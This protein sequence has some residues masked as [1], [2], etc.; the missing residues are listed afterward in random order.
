MNKTNTITIGID[1]AKNVFHLCTQDAKGHILKKTKLGRQQFKYFLAI[2]PPRRVVFESCA[3]AHDWSRVATRHGHDVKLIHPAYVKAYLKTNKNDFNDAEAMCEADS[4]PT[5]RYVSSKSIPQQDIQWL[6][7][8]RRRQVHQ[9]TALV[10]QIRGQLLAY[11]ITIP[12][13]ISQVRCQ[14]S[15]L[16]EEAENELSGDSRIL[17]HEWQQELYLMDDLVKQADKKINLIAKEHP[18]CHRLMGIP[19]IGPMIATALIN[20]VGNARHFKN[21]R[22]LSA[23]LGWVP[24]Q[25]STGG[26]QRLLG[27]S[28]RGDSYVRSLLVQGALSA[29]TRC[30]N[31]SDNP[32]VWARQLKETKGLQ[33]AAVALSNKMARIIWSVMAKDHDYVAHV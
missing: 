9:R 15:G 18:V 11:G 26:K 28:K 21:G 12:V 7:C 20:T 25:Y 24:K 19:G 17:F 6:H 8:I 13:G 3:T 22:E 30:K 32:L 10:N 33:K 23:W 14:L 29:M 1:L 27:I 16:L 31:R 4:R 5:M 2:T